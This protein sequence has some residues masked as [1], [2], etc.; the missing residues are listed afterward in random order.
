MLQ[1]LGDMAAIKAE[2]MQKADQV[3]LGVDANVETGFDTDDGKV[4]AIGRVAATGDHVLDGLTVC[5]RNVRTLGRS[6]F[7]GISLIVE[8]QHGAAYVGRRH[9]RGVQGGD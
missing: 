7:H 2:V 3:A 1:Q 6:I 9:A 4:V 8:T 5:I